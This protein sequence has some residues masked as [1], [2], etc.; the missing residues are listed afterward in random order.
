ML[1]CLNKVV[2]YHA[3][4]NGCIVIKYDGDF[5]SE[6]LRLRYLTLTVHEEHDADLRHV[7]WRI[8]E[9]QQ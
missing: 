8:Y 7:L 6:P 9:L 1:H 5:R 4:V 3:L 2:A